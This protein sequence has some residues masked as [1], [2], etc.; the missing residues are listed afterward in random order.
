MKR[1][2]IVLGILGLAVSM[3]AVA[4]NLF[5]Q[6]GNFCDF[7]NGLACIKVGKKAGYIDKS[8]KFVIEPKFYIA[9]SF[10]KGFATVWID[11]D[12][13]QMWINKAGN[14]VT[15]PVEEAI[16]ENKGSDVNKDS[17]AN[18]N[19]LTPSKI[20]NGKYGYINS[21]GVYVIEPKFTY[22]T[23]FKNGLAEVDLGRDEWG[24]INESGE[25]V[26][27]T[28][29]NRFQFSEGLVP[30]Y[31]NGKY[32]FSDKTGKFVIEAKFDEVHSF[33]NGLA[34]VKVDNKWGMINKMGKFVHKPMYDHEYRISEGLAFVSISG[35]FGYINS[36]TE[37]WIITPEKLAKAMAKY[38]V[39]VPVLKDCSPPKGN[40]QQYK[41]NCQNADCVR[42]YSNGCQKKFT[43][44]SCFDPLQNQWVFKPNGC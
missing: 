22:A 32:G 12:G 9:G 43:A 3:N 33:K 25:L 31:I 34:T 24:Y 39:P 18:K 19:E 11:A 8:A 38:E 21:S 4:E 16:D 26:I 14:S 28:N 10:E 6:D 41:D 13:D 30:H 36:S 44:P 40:S 17:D 1:L 23:N 7:H 42:T 29:K 37:K 20:S 35:K 27:N 2:L 15:Q 5:F